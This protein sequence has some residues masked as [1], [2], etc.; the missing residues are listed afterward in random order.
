MINFK[1]LL[2]NLFIIIFTFSSIAEEK[3]SKDQNTEFSVY[4]GMFDF[5]DDGKRST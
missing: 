3:V 5:S 2:I 1:Y 4:T